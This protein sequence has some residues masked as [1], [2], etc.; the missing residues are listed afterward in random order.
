MIYS[1]TVIKSWPVKFI[2]FLF[3]HYWNVQIYIHRPREQKVHGKALPDREMW[4]TKSD[5]DME[6]DSGKDA[7][8]ASDV[9]SATWKCKISKAYI[10]SICL[11][12][13]VTYLNILVL[14]MCIFLKYWSV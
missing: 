5:P 7:P 11:Y 14:V 2:Y 10:F 4:G 13:K 9:D 3:L 12:F 6:N 1:I 8:P